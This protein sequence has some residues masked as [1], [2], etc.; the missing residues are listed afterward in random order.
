MS[1]VCPNCGTARA[2][3]Y[4]SA[5]GQKDV[6]LTPTIGYFLHELT[7][8]LLHVDGKIFRSVRFLV[9]RPGFLTREI[10]AGRRASYVSPIRLYLVFS[11]FA[12]AAGALGV[13]GDGGV[14]ITYTPEPGEIVS[15][16]DIEARTAEIASN[17]NAAMK[18]WLPRAMFVLV[19]LFAALVMLFR[20]G[21]RRTYPQ[22]LYFALHV[23]AAWLFANGVSSLLD[24]VTR[25]LP[26]V[27]SA[28]G[29]LTFI[30]ALMYFVVAFHRIYATTVWGTLWR[31]ALIG[32]IYFVVLMLA[33]A[34]IVVPFIFDIGGDQ[35]S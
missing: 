6:P 26:Y 17:V 35:A 14:R 22:H 25:A 12:F 15:P 19:P 13:F 28:V 10:L 21:S 32:S 7:H 18:A 30:Y 2:G 4:C 5:C 1:S 9:T 23:H 11:I 34:S 20:R 24:T 29:S 8:E 31:T 3:R 16:E 33:M 27:A